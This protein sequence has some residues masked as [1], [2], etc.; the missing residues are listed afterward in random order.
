MACALQLRPGARPA[1]DPDE[2]HVDIAA[3]DEVDDIPEKT[4]KLRQRPHDF[5]PPL[6]FPL[7]SA[8][9]GSPGAA[10]NKVW[11]EGSQG[12]AV[13]GPLGRNSTPHAEPRSAQRGANAGAPAS[14]LKHSDAARL[15]EPG[16]EVAVVPEGWINPEEH[17]PAIVRRQLGDEP[18]ADDPQLTWTGHFERDGVT[19]PWNTSAARATTWRTR[20]RASRSIA[21]IR[22]CITASRRS[23]RR[24]IGP[25]HFAARHR[26]DHG[27][28]DRAA[29]L[30]RGEEAAVNSPEAMI[31][32]RCDV[33]ALPQSSGAGAHA[34]DRR[35]AQA[36]EP[37][38]IRLTRE[39]GRRRLRGPR[40]G[41]SMLAL[42]PR[43][44]ERLRKRASFAAKI[45][46]GDV[47]A[48]AVSL[49]HRSADRALRRSAAARL[50]SRTRSR[51]SSMAWPRS[52]NGRRCLAL[53][54]SDAWLS[55]PG[56]LRG[57]VATAAGAGCAGL[58]R[59][60]KKGSAPASSTG[61]T[62]STKAGSRSSS[63]SST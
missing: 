24:R 35:A 8:P 27:R 16:D 32:F 60:D 5:S 4:A 62:C 57:M 58:V 55:L 6:R 19:W 25:P 18:A 23:S 61:S 49:F 9:S 21:R 47:V 53:T 39:T 45:P 36:I 40:H 7:S 59:F 51:W 38:H 30:R 1:E 2:L 48:R 11:K 33:L 26:S 37:F 20:R 17:F 3:K 28:A 13:I 14:L 41:R 15:G 22:S 52:R 29:V 50:R 31:V 10:E 34:G 54:N 43:A 46:A 12:V 63:R 42:R 56:G 44:G